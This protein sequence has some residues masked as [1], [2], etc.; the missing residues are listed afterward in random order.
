MFLIAVVA[1]AAI[2]ASPTISRPVAPTPVSRPPV[3][4]TRITTNKRPEVPA[5]GYLPQRMLQ[6]NAIDCYRL[7]LLHQMPPNCPLLFIV[8]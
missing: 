4:S 5:L 7:E 6:Q 8:P 2:S 3:T 1:S